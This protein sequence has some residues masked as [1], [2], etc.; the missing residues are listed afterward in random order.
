MQQCPSDYV[1]MHENLIDQT[2]FPFLH[3]ETVGTPE[4][5][6]SRLSAS[7][8]GNQVIIRRELRDSPPPG[9]YGKPADIMD[10]NVDRTSEARFVSPALHVA[11][12][13]I[14]DNAPDAGKPERYRYNISHCFTPATN[15][16]IHYWWFN[17]RDYRPGDPEID[18]FMTE[19]SS[20]AYMEDVEAL[21]W[22]MDVVRNDERPQID[23][24]FA[25]DKPG[26][27]ARRIMYRLAM[28]ER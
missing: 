28:K 15:T 14:R 17:S 19:A 10:K 3:P 24:S 6:R 25:P 11:F 13:E 5:A 27:M 7:T 12:A 23:L 20:Q 16:S 4:Y 18:A 8:E 21:E 22:I 26:L 9:V 1:A 2:H